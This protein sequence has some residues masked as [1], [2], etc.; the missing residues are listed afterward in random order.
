LDY[1]QH[2]LRRAEAATWGAKPSPATA[3]IRTFRPHR[4]G[5]MRGFFAVETPAGLVLHD[6]RLMEGKD[7]NLWVA[8]PSVPVLDADR[9]QQV[10]VNG[11]SV[12]RPVAEFRDRAAAQRFAQMCLDALDARFPSGLPSDEGEP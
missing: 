1:P 5:S 7:G 4:S 6:C 2:R 12:W 3:R 8:L 10:D 9:R 11:R